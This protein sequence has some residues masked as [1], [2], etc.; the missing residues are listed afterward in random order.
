MS[1]LEVVQ[2]VA[3]P[4]ILIALTSSIGSYMAAVYSG[5]KTVLGR[6][7]GPIE[8]LV[9]RVCLVNPREEMHWKKYSFAV[10]SLTM[11]S[12]VF[13]FAFLVFQDVL[14]FN[15]NKNT[16]VPWPL[17]LNTAV[18]FVTNTNWQAYSAEATLSYGAQ[19]FALSVQNFLSAA[20]GMSILLV[21]IRAL[22]RERTQ[23]LG[24]FWVDLTRSILYVLLPLSV[25]IAIVLVSQGVIQNL[26]TNIISI[27]VEG[28]TQL[29]PMGPA[30][31]QVAIKQLG[32]NGGGFFGVNSAHP[33]ENP[34]PFSNFLQMLAIL[35]IPSAQVYMFGVM[36]KARKHALMIYA[37][38]FILFSVSL[39]VALW[40]EYQPNLSLATHEALEG[41]EVR[42]GIANSILW[43]AATTAAS[44]GSVNSMLDSAS[45]LAGAMAFFQ[46]ILGEVVFGGVGAGLYGMFLFILLTVFLAGLMVGRTPEYFGKKLEAFEMK[47]ALVAIIAPNSVILLGA[48]LSVFL[49]AAVASI[50]NAGPHGLSEILY[51]FASASQNNGSAFAGLMVDTSYF[52]LMLAFCMLVG[53]YVIIFSILL[54]AGSMVEKTITPPSLGTFTTDVPIFAVLLFFCIFIIGALTFVPAISLSSIAEHFL[55]G[56]GQT[57]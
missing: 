37:V 45:P 52:N 54:I 33:F 9:Y 22:T 5:E 13:T 57:F 11:L 39:G 47:W 41:K 12:L 42:H 38:M 27:G 51:A 30:A 53:R 28:A 19:L 29:L 6:I 10:L 3:Y 56:A 24:N 14:G 8:N 18:S 32:T 20:T 36:T 35:L 48:A 40:S 15:P 1:G 7:L 44:N 49:Q 23:N 55:M 2:I 16:G 4:V 21:V 26:S 31:S 50:H 17:A 25:L 34:T 46:I 43:S